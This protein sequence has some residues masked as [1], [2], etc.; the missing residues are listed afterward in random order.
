[1]TSNRRRQGR[2]AAAGL[3]ILLIFAVSAFGSSSPSS[4]ATAG[5]GP[6]TPAAVVKAIGKLTTCLGEHG[7]KVPAPVT[8][9]GV[10]TTI[11]NLPSAQRS[12]VITACQTQIDALLAMRPGH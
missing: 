8:R 1:M 2:F 5:A 4:G 9:K 12:A 6:S 7:V 3:A 10:R 11:R